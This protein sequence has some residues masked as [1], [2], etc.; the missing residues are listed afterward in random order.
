MA[1]IDFSTFPRALPWDE[2]LL[3]GSGVYRRWGAFLSPL[4]R[5]LRGALRE[6]VRLCGLTGG[7]QAVCWRWASPGVAPYL[8]LTP[9]LPWDQSVC[10]GVAPE[11]CRLE[12]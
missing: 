4:S 7:G 5:P 3:G 1:G 12:E 8:L 10:S 11:G 9:T 6:V 2:L